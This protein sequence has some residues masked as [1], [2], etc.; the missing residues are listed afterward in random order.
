MV[1]IERLL[2]AD[3]VHH[4]NDRKW[5]QNCLYAFAREESLA[6]DTVCQRSNWN[7]LFWL[8]A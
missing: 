1:F 5:A 8:K 3:A 6:S 7:R 4:L 2:L